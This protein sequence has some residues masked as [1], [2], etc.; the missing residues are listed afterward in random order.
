MTLRP[1]TNL[2]ARIRTMIQLFNSPPIRRITPLAWMLQGEVRPGTRI[3]GVYD[4]AEVEHPRRAGFDV[5]IRPFGCFGRPERPFC[6]PPS[7]RITIMNQEII[8]R[9]IRPAGAAAD[10]AARAHRAAV[11]RGADPALRARRPRRRAWPSRDLDRVGQPARRG[12]ASSTTSGAWDM[13]VDRARA[14]SRRAAIA[15]PER[16]HAPPARRAERAAARDGALHAAAARRVRE[17]SL[18]ARRSRSPG[19]IVQPVPEEADRVYADAVARP[20][21]DAQ[22]LVA[23]RESRGDPS[24]AR[25]LWRR[26]AVRSRSVWVRRRSSRSR[27]SCRRTSRVSCSTASLGRRRPGR[28]HTAT[29]GA[30]GVARVSARWR[31]LYV[32]RQA[33]AHVR[34]RLMSVLGEWVARDLRVR[35]VRA[36]SATQPVV[37]LAQEDGKPDHARHRGHRSPVGVHRLRRR[38]RVAVDGHAARAGRG[39]AHAGLAARVS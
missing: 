15:G 1:Q 12:R 26:T 37:L 10:R 28:S 20:V 39:A 9:Y 29:R 21:R 4:A 3:S 17:H 25:L 18:R 22:A 30:A 7:Q 14:D 36:H 19:A 34:L 5:V 16:E 23:G 8:S 31:A 2:R 32:V 11:G 35:V 13:R 6:C 38:R 33:A 27:A 24:P